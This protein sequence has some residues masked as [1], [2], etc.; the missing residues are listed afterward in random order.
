AHRDDIADAVLIDVGH[1]VDP[2][3]QRDRVRDLHERAARRVADQIRAAG[4]AIGARLAGGAA[5]EVAARVAQRLAVAVLALVEHEV[6]A[7]IAEIRQLAARGRGQ[8][9]DHAEELHSTSPGTSWMMSSLPGCCRPLVERR[10][11]L[12]VTFFV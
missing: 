11:G 3:L 8:R 12:S 7:A 6:A 9:E 10:R 2:G 4:I 5:M 1:A